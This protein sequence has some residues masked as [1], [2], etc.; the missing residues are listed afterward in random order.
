MMTPTQFSSRLMEHISNCL[1]EYVGCYGELPEHIIISLR[2]YSMLR[3]HNAEQ[4]S[5]T[6]IYGVK[7]RIRDGRKS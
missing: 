5:S 7:I 6:T 2:L 1:V 3:E 4:M